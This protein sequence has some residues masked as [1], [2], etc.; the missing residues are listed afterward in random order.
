MNMTT[1]YLGLPLRNPLVASASPLSRSID[2]VRRMEDAGLAAVVCYSLF[3][4]E[5]H[6][7]ELS[8]DHYLHHGAEQYS[9]ALDYFP[10]QDRYD[11]GPDSYLAHI[12]QMK[13]AVDI[14][15]I[16]SLNGTTPGGWTE[17][18]RQIAH[19][20]AD[21]LELN[22]YYI[23]TDPDEEAGDVEDRYLDILAEVKS[24]IDIPV[25][26]K[27]S[28]YFSS[29]ANMAGKLDRAGADGLVLFNRFYQPDIDIE[30]LTVTP[31][32]MLSTPFASRVPLRWIAILYGNVG[33]HLAHT[34]GIH[35]HEDVIKA[36]LA[37]AQVAMAAS[38][39]LK[40]GIEHATGILTQMEQ[41]L[42]EHEYE[43]VNQ[44]RGSMSQMN[45]E[46]PAAFERANYIKA[47]ET[48][49]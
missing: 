35:T 34:G 15:V 26:V 44:M 38:A 40:N 20:G 24:A 28:P 11:V 22:V 33:A 31:N 13:A 47:L 43:S 23:A 48:Y 2:N 5:I 45:C 6:H 9:E 32:V 8:L 36:L 49:M 39:L 30:S 7:G 29:M 46:D 42:D 37:G 25:A 19:A 41:W 16:G 27:L 12:E 3:E 17:Y 1:E 10:E 21:A 14:P 4:E 18:A